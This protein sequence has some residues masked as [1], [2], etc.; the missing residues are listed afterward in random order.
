MNRITT[1]N[2]VRIVEN[3]AILLMVVV[4]FII[5]TASF[6]HIPKLE[7]FM[8]HYLEI[9]RILRRMIAIILLISA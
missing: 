4:T 6:L 3:L 1:K 2:L 8:Y 5:F 9:N 7:D